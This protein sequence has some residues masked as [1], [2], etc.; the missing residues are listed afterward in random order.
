SKVF[1]KNLL[2]KY[3]I[4]T[5]DFR[6]FTEPHV[7]ELYVTEQVTSFPIV[8]KADGLA[9]G[10]G[11]GVAQGAA[12]AKGGSERRMRRPEFGAAGRRVVVEECLVGEEISVLAV[13]DGKTL[14]TLEPARDHK[15]V[16]DGDAGPNTGGMGA[17]CPSPLWSP[18]L[19]Q[20]IESRV[21]VPT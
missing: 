9:A 20:E 14:C 17:F 7:A 15:R 16:F 21:L 1:T 10:K 18:A 2:R 12:G 8:V 19:E 6:V 3:H 5:A 4:P 13:T 11:G